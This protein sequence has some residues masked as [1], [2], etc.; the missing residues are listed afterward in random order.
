MTEESGSMREEPHKSPPEEEEG[1]QPA[2]S[3]DLPGGSA[4]GGA[5]TRPE[6]QEGFGEATPGEAQSEN[7]PE[8]PEMIREDQPGGEQ[9]Q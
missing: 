9:S 3:D 4:P 1:L 8:D 7:P 2:G 6:A 5:Q